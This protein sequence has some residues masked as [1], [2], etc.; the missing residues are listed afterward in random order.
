MKIAINTDFCDSVCCAEP[1]L[2]LI[3][4]AGFTH[5]HWCHE[6]NSDFLYS[7][8]EIAEIALWLKRYGLTLLDIH[9]SQGSH[10][11]WYATE[12]YRRKSGIELVKNRIRMC[13]E[14]EAQ[15][16]LIMHIPVLKYTMSEDERSALAPK[17]DSLKRSLDEIMPELEKYNVTLAIENSSSDT[18]EM[19]YDIMKNYPAKY[20]GIT[21]D[22][23]HGNIN[24]AKGLDLVEKVK[25][26]IE[27]LHL[28]DNDHSGDLH[29][30][31][32]FGNVDWDRVVKLLA[33]SKYAETGRPLSF[34]LSIAN[35]PFYDKEL[36]IYQSDEN[37]RAFLADTYKRCAVIVE[38]Y[39][40]L[41]K[42]KK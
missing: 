12:E 20:V 15:G 24:E 33:N 5:I 22:S 42:L 26:R 32:M 9:G 14:L 29:Q 18:F 4:E 30:P 6:W 3:A 10:K 16:G 11:L 13:A 1:K 36:G 39:E 40:S 25:D 17:I 19:I 21:Y 28:N 2:K 37:I 27:V 7:K 8:Y 31:P 38:K 41:L 35:T 34:E 23:G